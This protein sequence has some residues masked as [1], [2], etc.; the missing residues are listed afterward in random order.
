[1]KT[2]ILVVG[3]ENNSILKGILLEPDYYVVNDLIQ[4]F[5]ISF[6]QSIKAVFGQGAIL[7]SNYQTTIL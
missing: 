7:Y 3:H 6:E 2:F 1:M 5:V 4:H